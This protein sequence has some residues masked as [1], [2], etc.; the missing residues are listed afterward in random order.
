MKHIAFV[1]YAL[2]H[3]AAS[4]SWLHCVNYDKN[5]SLMSGTIDNSKCMAYPRDITSEF[6]FGVDRGIDYQPANGKPCRTS[7]GLMVNYRKGG[8]YR[9]LWPA[10]NHQS[11][12]CT[13]PYIPD[14]QLKVFFYPT[15][16]GAQDPSLS[17][18]AQEKYL[19]QDFKK[20]GKGFQ[21][22]PD[23][24]SNTD[25]APCFGDLKVPENFGGFYKVL[26][27]WEFNKGQIY[28]HC[29]DVEVSESDVQP[30]SVPKTNSPAS[31]SGMY[32][33]CGGR[34]WRGATCC[35]EGTCTFSNIDYSQC[36]PNKTP[37]ASPALSPTASPALSP[38]A[39]PTQ[40][41]KICRCIC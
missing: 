10:K 25:K 37:T 40:Q 23:F 33:Q 35:R 34:S 29:Y 4:H 24:C 19:V 26:W 38:T 41:W 9:L 6:V 28:T 15:T 17:E 18:W 1:L 13:N 11:D 30:S 27:Y 22:C 12:V 31:C 14:N 5:A 36:L 2:L 3:I 16:A 32:G 7:S 39:S 8:T 21:N 20:N